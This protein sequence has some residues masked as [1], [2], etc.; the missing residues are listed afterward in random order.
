[1]KKGRPHVWDPDDYPSL[2]DMPLT[3][4]EQRAVQYW[5]QQL[6]HTVKL[7]KAQGPQAFHLA[8]RK[9]A[10]DRIYAE[11]LEL[12]RNP[13]LSRQ[14]ARSLFHSLLFPPPEPKARPME[15]RDDDDTA[16]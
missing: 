2:E 3:G 6:P 11:K 16:A 9:A 10:Y 8:I 4:E 13:G 14:H 5:E 7:L 12:A 1:M 15:P